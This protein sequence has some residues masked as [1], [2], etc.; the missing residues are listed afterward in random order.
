MKSGTSFKPFHQVSFNARFT[1]LLSLALGVFASAAAPA[2]VVTTLTSSLGVKGDGI[3]VSPSGELY[4]A[5]GFGS[6]V[7]LQISPSGTVSVFAD[8]V[9]NAVGAYLDRGGDLFVNNYRTNSITRI[10]KTGKATVLA[11]DLNGPAGIVGNGHGDLFVTEFG[12]NLSGNGA[13]VQRITQSGAKTP[14]V[15]GNGL[16]DPVGIALDEHGGL[17]VSNWKSGE[18]HKIEDGS[19]RRVAL[20]DGTINQIAYS[21]GYLYVPSPSLRKI[22]RVSSDGVVTHIA[23]S[24]ASGTTDGPAM[25]ATF[26]RPNSVAVAPNGAMLYIVDAEAQAIRVLKLEE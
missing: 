19:A 9:P 21:G 23:G 16:R 25:Q 20:I 5:G 2:Q 11:T 24:G 17:Y 1:A 13:A 8:G 7:V 4:V 15:I 14:Y 3:A 12:A 22:F 18:I 6:N 26:R 10:S